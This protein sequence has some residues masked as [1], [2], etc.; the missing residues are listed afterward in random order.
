M[1]GRPI[2]SAEQRLAKKLA[3]LDALIAALSIPGEVRAFALAAAPEGWLEANGS[4]VLIA[5]YASLATAIYCGNSLNATADWGYRATQATSPSTHRSTSGTYIVLP[6]YRGE[7]LRGWDN[8]RGKDSGRGLWS[9][10]ADE[11]ESHTHTATTGSDGIHDHT[12]S[13][14]TTGAHTHNYERGSVTTNTNTTASGASAR[15][16]TFDETLTA[17]SSD[18]NHTHSVVVNGNGLHNHSVSVASAGGTETRPTNLAAL[19][20]IR[21]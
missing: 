13:V 1:P 19:I 5:D 16:V 3:R 21:T 7:F 17:T 9:A 6:D 10:Q 4:A 15:V 14:S 11:L 20:C 8:G 12:T 2:N 18:G